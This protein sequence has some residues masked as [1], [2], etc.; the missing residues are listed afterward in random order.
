[1]VS[2][3]G[4]VTLWMAINSTGGIFF[5]RNPNQGVLP[6]QPGNGTGFRNGNPDGYGFVDFGDS[7][8]LTADRVPDYFFR[9]YRVVPATQMFF[10]TYYNPYISR[11]QRFLP[12]V[13]CG[14]PHP[15]SNLPA[16]SAEETVHPYQSTLNNTPQA[17]PAPGFSGRVEAPPVNPGSTGLRP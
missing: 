9:R 11:G 3:V 4:S 14:G 6:Q 2:L 16:Q 15:A 10:P 1:M 7:L 8:P 13:G 17:P 5:N 12:Y